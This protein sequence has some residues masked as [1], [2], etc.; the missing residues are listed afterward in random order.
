LQHTSKYN[1][2]FDFSQRAKKRLAK[3][4]EQKLKELKTSDRQDGNLY[5]QVIEVTVV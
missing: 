1:E 3:D 2:G 5:D 4:R